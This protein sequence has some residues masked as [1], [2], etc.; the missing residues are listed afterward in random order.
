MEDWG[1]MNECVVARETGKMAKKYMK[2]CSAS[3]VITEMPI[4]MT[5]RH[6]FIPT[7]M[8]TIKRQT[9]TSG[10]DVEKLELSCLTGGNVK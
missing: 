6:H 8:A 4:K 1:I 2:R 9:V 10:K 7:R 3:L 5:M